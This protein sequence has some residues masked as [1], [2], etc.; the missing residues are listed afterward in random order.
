MKT[1]PCF[2]ALF[3]F[4]TAVI[5]CQ[6]AMPMAPANIKATPIANIK[7]LPAPEP[8]GS[9]YNDEDNALARYMRGEAI[10][11]DPNGPTTKSRVLYMCIVTGKFNL[12]DDEQS[13]TMETWCVESRPTGGGGISMI[14]V[15]DTKA[16][17]VPGKH[18][19]RILFRDAT[20]SVQNLSGGLREVRLHYQ[21]PQGTFHHVSLTSRPGEKYQYSFAELSPDTI[22]PLGEERL[23]EV[24]R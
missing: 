3:G 8:I 19:F 17:R 23:I 20:V 5:G 4:L 12:A 15:E 24:E 18:V 16:D 11:T 6:T 22:E 21:D 13:L 2:L 7:P 10:E 9:L 14:Q 1:R